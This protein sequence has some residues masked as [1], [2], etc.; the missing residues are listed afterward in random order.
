MLLMR[1]VSKCERGS[2]SGAF[3]SMNDSAFNRFKLIIPQYSS[4]VIHKRMALSSITI[5][6]T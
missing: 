6:H 4:K 3:V 1:I 2:R 5:S